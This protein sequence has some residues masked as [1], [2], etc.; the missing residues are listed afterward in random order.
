VVNRRNLLVGLTLGIPVSSLVRA[1]RAPRTIG[2][3]LVQPHRQVEGYAVPFDD[4]MQKLGYAKGRDYVMIERFAEG[5]IDR[6]PH[7]ASDLVELKV[8]VIVVSSTPVAAAAQRATAAIPIVFDGVA[9]PVRAGFADSLAHPGH[10]MSGLS[11][12]TFELGPKR[13]QLLKQMVPTLV[14]VAYLGNPT[15]PY[16]AKAMEWMQPQV[17][18]LGLHLFFANA[19]KRDEL[20]LA[21]RSMV[22]QRAEAVLVSGDVLFWTDRTE[23]RWSGT[24]RAR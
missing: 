5:K 8:D 23:S 2:L 20:E 14:R 7:L 16:R 22:E 1:Q 18:Q 12:F 6:L 11:N 15:S 17:D 9:D 24:A 4:A 19:T 3:L 10:N 13:L 21:F